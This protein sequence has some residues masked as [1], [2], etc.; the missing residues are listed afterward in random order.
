MSFCLST[1]II[2]FISKGLDMKIFIVLLVIAF[3]GVVCCALSDD[4]SDDE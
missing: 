2:I 4:G 1:E 3:I